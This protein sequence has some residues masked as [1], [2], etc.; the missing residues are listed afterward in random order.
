M[1]K[2]IKYS[3]YN[4]ILN[5]YEKYKTFIHF[6]IVGFINTGVDFVTFSILF[7]FFHIDKLICQVFGYSVGIVNSFIMNKIFTFK[8][9]DIEC[10]IV[11]QS[12]RFISVNVVSLG[13]SII[14]LGILNYN[15]CINV[16][17]SKLIITVI[18]QGINYFGYKLWVFSS[19]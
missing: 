10:S 14:A 3:F 15:L 8:E 6:L 7:S 12:V 2:T 16:Y 18:A 1:C 17:M 9:K 5:L 19:K 13:I 11:I 4:N